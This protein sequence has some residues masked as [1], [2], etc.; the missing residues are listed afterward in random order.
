MR[1]TPF[2]QRLLPAP[3][4]GGFRR[5]DAWIWCGSVIRDD[6]GAFHMFASM[7]E[8]TVPFSPHW[9]TNSRVTHAVSPT[10]EGPYVYRG[11]VLPPRGSSWWDGRMTHNP[12]IHRYRDQ[13][14]L[15]YTGTTYPEPP[16]GPGDHVTNE[17]VSACRARQRVGLAVA[18]SLDGPWRRPDHPC[19]ETRPGHWDWFMTTNP[20]PCVLSDGRILLLYKSSSG[21]AAPL[22]YGVAMA[23]SP[24]VPFDRIGPDRPITFEQPDIT[25]EDATVWH[26]DRRYQML[27]NDLSGTLAGEERAGAHAVS[28]DGIHWRLNHPPK[29]Y[30]RTVRWADGRV[31]TQGSLE[32]PQVLIQDGVPTHLFCATSDGRTGFTDAHH[33]W[34]MVMPLRTGR[35][36]FGWRQP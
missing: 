11:D 14:L 21:A 25:Y 26:Q 4:D 1:S 23:E 28:D 29:A 6:H 33:T 12:T 5:E 15:F 13:Y 27:F 24:S 17:M 2:I 22:R 20:A 3:V 32:R 16:P 9:L 36:R 10:P 8:K 30:S 34:N 19:L 7:W 18:D 35:N 31:T